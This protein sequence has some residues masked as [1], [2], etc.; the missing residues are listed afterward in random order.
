[1][2]YGLVAR[3]A[4][5]GR[6]GYGVASSRMAVGHVCCD[7]VR[8]GVGV[9]ITLGFPRPAN[10]LL[11]IR[12]L[13]QGFSSAQVLRALRGNDPLAAS[14]QIVVMDRE[15]VAAADTGTST[16]SWAGHQTDLNLAVFGDRLCGQLIIEA[17]TRSFGANSELELEE[18]LLAALEAGRVAAAG[19]GESGATPALSAALSVYGVQDYSDWDLRV[20]MHDDAVVELRRVHEEYQLMAA[21]YIERAKN[22]QAAKTQMEFVDMLKANRPKVMP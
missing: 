14:R 2:N 3:C 22:P 6:L 16:Q 5:T 19:Q 1:M 10:N 20:D 11:G 7:A 18:R 8:A 13:G 4:R 9:A 17:L 12:L 21:Y 15:G